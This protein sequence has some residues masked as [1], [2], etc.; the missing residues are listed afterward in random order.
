MGLTISPDVFQGRMNAIFGS[1]PGCIVY[2][3]DLLVITK[4]TF[5]EHLNL[6]RQVFQL[7]RQNNIQVNAKKSHFFAPKLEY[8]GADIVTGR[9]QG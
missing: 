5:E 4:G 2:I 7:C 9:H 3:D 6:L 8:L 1:V